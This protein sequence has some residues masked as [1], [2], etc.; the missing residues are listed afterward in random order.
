MVD[1]HWS[2][3]DTRKRLQIKTTGESMK[4]IE[5]YLREKAFAFL[6]LSIKGLCKE[7]DLDEKK[8]SHKFNELKKERPVPDSTYNIYVPDGHMNF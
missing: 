2:Y 5:S 6:G 4:K 7:L 3:L 8:L 1:G